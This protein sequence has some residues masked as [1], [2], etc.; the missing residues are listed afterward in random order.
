MRSNVS[1]ACRGGADGAEVGTQV[2]DS[3]I[4]QDDAFSLCCKQIIFQGSTRNDDAS[5]ENAL[6]F[7]VSSLKDFVKV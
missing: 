2:A 7:K 5:P 1:R 3:S 4:R 6:D